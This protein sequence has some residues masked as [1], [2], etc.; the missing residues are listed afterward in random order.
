ME[1]IELDLEK[2]N[3]SELIKTIESNNLKLIN[4]LH[5]IEQMESKPQTDLN[6]NEISNKLLSESIPISSKEDNENT[7]FENEVDY[8]FSIIN[9]FGETQNLCENIHNSLPSKKN[10]NYKNIVLR[11]KMELLKN[12][13]DINDLLKEEEANLSTE[14]LE[15]FKNEIKLNSKKIK[16]ISTIENS[17]ALEQETEEIQNNLIFVPT[18]SG[19]IRVLEELN[20]ISQEYFPGFKGLFESIIDGSFKN[21]KRFNSSNSK[22][23]GISEVKDFKIRVVYDRIGPNDYAVITAFIKKSDRDRGYLEALN[24]KIKNYEA[25]KEELKNNLSNPEFIKIQNQYTNELLNM[26]ETKDKASYVYR[27]GEK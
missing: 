3:E 14:I 12:I 7:D 18:S 10:P 2:A 26:L 8:Y 1:F 24:L 6:S 5:S 15:D 22:N 13:K 23:S 17:V 11:V 21:V 4:I 16:M 19:N 25:Q 20:D 9:R 27:K